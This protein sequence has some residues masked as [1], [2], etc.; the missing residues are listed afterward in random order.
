MGRTGHL[1]SVRRWLA[2]CHKWQSA[3]PWTFPGL[4]KKHKR[5]SNWMQVSNGQALEQ[6][7]FQKEQYKKG[8]KCLQELKYL[9]LWTQSKISKDCKDATIAH[10]YKRK[11]NHQLCVS[12][13]GTSLLKIA[14]E[15]LA[16]MLVNHLN[17]RPF[18]QYDFCKEW[19]TV[20]MTFTIELIHEKYQGQHVNLYTMYIWLK[21]LSQ[22]AEKAYGKLWRHLDVLRNSHILY[23]SI[24]PWWYA[25]TAHQQWYSL[26]FCF[27]FPMVVKQGCVLAP[28]LFCLR[29]TE[30]LWEAYKEEKA[31]IDIWYHT[32]RKLFSLQTMT[33][34]HPQSAHC[35]T[36]HL[37]TTA[38]LRQSHFKICKD[39]LNYSPPPPV[40]TL[41]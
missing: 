19:G 24:I 5:L 31:G 29:L 34:S 15:I 21:R 20:D 22:C 26:L 33:H 23:H 38:F 6:I 16:R 32:D 3:V 9:K 40:T 14:G 30:M 35:V 7:P 37:L 11:T 39:V 41:V 1:K 28:N 17:E 2:G 27:L 18:F 36:F 13:W 8:D 10:L 4:W 25:T 12:D